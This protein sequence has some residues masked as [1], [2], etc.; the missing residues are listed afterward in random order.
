M[1]QVIHLPTIEEP[2]PS[3]RDAALE[4][5]SDGVYL[6][7]LRFDKASSGARFKAVAKHGTR[8]SWLAFADD[9][10]RMLH[11]VEI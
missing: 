11:E 5:Y 1:G 9:G 10:T 3:L 7:M 2:E 6:A 8:D 4:A